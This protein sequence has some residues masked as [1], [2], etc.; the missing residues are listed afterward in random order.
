[1]VDTNK[2]AMTVKFTKSSKVKI[3]EAMTDSKPLINIAVKGVLNFL[4][5]LPKK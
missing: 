2:V 5:R 4:Q 1:M 3:P